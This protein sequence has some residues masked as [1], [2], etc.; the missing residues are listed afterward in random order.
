MGFLE[1]TR[2]ETGRVYRGKIDEIKET[3]SKKDCADFMEAL[4]DISISQAAIVRA[5]QKRG[6]RIGTGT[7]SN[8]RREVLSNRGDI[9]DVS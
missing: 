1:E 5:L 8:L 2:S 9:N 7:I 6:V 3:L 4:N